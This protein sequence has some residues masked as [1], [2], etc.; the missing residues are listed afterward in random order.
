MA[1]WLM[2]KLLK[3]TL[4]QMGHGSPRVIHF[5][6]PTWSGHIT[7]RDISKK[8]YVFTVLCKLLPKYIISYR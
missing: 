1:R 8:I 4:S 3:Y 2:V 7:R 5:G 6:K